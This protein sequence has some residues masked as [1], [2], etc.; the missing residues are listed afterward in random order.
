MSYLIDASNLGGALGG[1]RGARDAETVV[2]FLLPCSRRRGRVVT[3][4]DGTASARVAD[5][6][7]GLEVIWSGAGRSADEEIVRRVAAAPREWIV[8]TDDRELAARCRELGVRVQPVA[9]LAEQAAAA[10]QREG[11]KGEKPEVSAAERAHWR[12]IFGDDPE[13]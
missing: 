4:F 2:R 13:R 9:R 8:V 5:R 12:R 10:R 7:G 6:Y 11:S 3:V 1:Q